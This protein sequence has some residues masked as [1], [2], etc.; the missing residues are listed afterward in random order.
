MSQPKVAIVGATGAVGIDLIETLEKRNFPLSELRLLA[1]ARSAG[2]KL[3]YRGKEITVE[4]LTEDSFEG[5]DIALFSAGGSI[6]RKFGPAAVKAGAVVVDNSS[7]F[8]MDPDTPLVIPEI[9]PEDAK[10]H[11]GIIANPNCSTIIMLM[12]VYPIHKINPVKRIIVSTYQAASGAGW[13]A[14]E[15]LK[16]QARDILDGKPA[17]PKVLPYQAAFNVFSHNSSMDLDLGYN[18]EEVKMVKETHKILHDDS[19]RISP[20]CIRVPTLR[21]HAESIHLELENPADLDAIRNAIDSFPGAKILDDRQE[22]R[23]PMPVDASGQDDVLVG[24]IR[25]DYASTDR[26][27]IELFVVGDQLLKGAALNAVQI[28]ELLS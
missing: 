24:R 2:K 8:R 27:E 16:S 19:I 20:T 7:A 21:A 3:K 15:E 9:N 25:A 4:E 12:A 18:Q 11:R 22:N 1:S 14:M 26:R 23:F 6:S 10:K 5:I 13:A 28:A 17:Q